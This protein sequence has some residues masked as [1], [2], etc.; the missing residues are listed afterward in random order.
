MSRNYAVLERAGLEAPLPPR[1]A[2]APVDIV[3]PRGEYL[4]LIRR[5]FRTPAAVAIVGSGS[6]RGAADLCEGIAAE[7]AASGNR[8]VVVPVAALL[9]MNPVPVPG[10]T[11]YAPGPAPNIWLWPAPAGAQ[12]EFFKPHVPADALPWLDS[13][14]RNFDSVLLDCPAP[15]TAPGA[16]EIAAMADAAVL[17]VEAGLTTKLQVRRDHRTLQ[18]KGVKLAGAILIRRR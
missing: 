5:L 2:P 11:A 8:V 12:L 6:K 1:A 17:A 7:L 14:R 15:E 9:R 13:L 18:S 10:E 16:A 3:T 4:E